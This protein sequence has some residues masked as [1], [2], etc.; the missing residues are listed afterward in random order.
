MNV[1][2]YWK[3]GE[4]EI[5][6]IFKPVMEERK[7]QIRKASE[8]GHK[9]LDPTSSFL[10]LN[11][12][13]DEDPAP[14]LR[15]NALTYTYY[16]TLTRTTRHCTC[17]S[18]PHFRDS[19]WQ[20]W[21]DAGC[22]FGLRNWRYTHTVCITSGSGIEVS[23]CLDNS[24]SLRVI[25]IDFWRCIQDAS[26]E[27]KQQVMVGQTRFQSWRYNTTTRLA[28]K[29]FNLLKLFIIK[30]DTARYCITSYCESSPEWNFQKDLSNNVLPKE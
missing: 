20:G 24:I 14:C 1:V 4:T 26:A 6:D 12:C 16:L 15:R 29:A 8:S 10:K 2:R 25:S 19:L 17:R 9:K 13:Q 7:R 3:I 21:M 18:T 11:P 22:C 28:A 27:H 30:K 23:R 5:S